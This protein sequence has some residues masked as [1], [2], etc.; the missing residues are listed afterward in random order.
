MKE[1]VSFVDILIRY[2]S[3]LLS[4][5]HNLID[6]IKMYAEKLLHIISF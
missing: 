4:W 6:S 2:L 1:I 5:P 3:R